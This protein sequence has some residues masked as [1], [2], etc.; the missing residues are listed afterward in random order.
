MSVLQARAA[1]MR[2]LRF[3]HCVLDE[4]LGSLTAPDGSTS[5]LRPKTFELLRLLLSHAGRV[6]SRE[7]ILDA[8]W[9]G[10]FVTDDSVTQCVV[11]IRKAI[12][13][14]GAGLLKTI[15]R[16][17]YLLQAEV[18]AESAAG[19]PAPGTPSGV[20]TV[21]VLSFRL[22]RSDDELE[23]VADGIA[24][25]IVGALSTFREPIVISR[26]STR[27][28]GYPADLAA[29]G[30]RL[31]ADSIVSGSIGRAAS[32]VRLTVELAE[33]PSGLVQWHR[34]YTLAPDNTF[35]AQDEI[36]AVIANTLAPHV[37]Q[38][39]LRRSQARP[40]DMTAYHLLLNAKAKMFRM[41]RTAMEEAAALLRR[42]IA[43]D[44]GYAAAHAAMAHWHM[45]HVGQGW[46]ADRGASAAAAEADL[47]TALGLDPRNARALALLGHL[48]TILRC[49]LDGAIELL[50]RALDVAPNDAEVWLWS[51]PT[52]AW[53]A[54]AQEAIRRAE[55]AMLLSPEDPLLFLHAHFR[56]IAHYVAGEH[57]ASAHWGKRSMLLNP[58]YTSN[59]RMT[60]AALVALGRAEDARALAARV[61]ALEPGFR[62]AP[63]IARQPLRNPA[64]RALYGKRLLAAGLPV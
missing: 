36:A 25:G 32:G 39:D 15:P 4:G 27:H 34:T 7:E 63:M 2:R 54:D 28:F 56:A 19:V 51:V 59:L 48:R 55:R 21:A 64:A 52:H 49:D 35:E 46:S 6:V 50:D 1:G 14:G 3:G 62:V 29:I 38:A 42:A 40:D 44:P 37:Q 16:R 41:D 9:P 45:L 26:N 58:D 8:V 31:G 11:E 5:V 60:A 17:G 12:G 61:V 43:L 20:S 53:R 10:I 47:R 18:V 57:E 23:A 30:R 33:A 13:Q 22:L 24:E